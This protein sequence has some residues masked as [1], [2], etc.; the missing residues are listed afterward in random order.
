MFY[1][2]YIVIRVQKNPVLG[3]EEGVGSKSDTTMNSLEY[4]P[5]VKSNV[6]WFK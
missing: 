4:N 6:D 3:R 1:S 5:S 2:S